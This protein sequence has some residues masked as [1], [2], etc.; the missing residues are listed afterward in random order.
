MINFLE[1]IFTAKAPVRE[2][3]VQR[4]SPFTAEQKSTSRNNYVRLLERAERDADAIIA[5][6]A[7][8]GECPPAALSDFKIKGFIGEGQ[9][10]RVFKVRLKVKG[11]I[12]ALKATKK[13]RVEED[14][15]VE[16][17]FREK[18]LQ[19]AMSFPFI[20]SLH[21]AFHDAKCVYLVTE[22]AM[23]GDLFSCFGG[24]KLHPRMAKTF[25]AQIIM[26]LE[27]MHACRLA[28]RDLKPGNVFIFEDGYVKLG[29]FG[30]T[31]KVTAKTFSTL[32]TAQYLA[33]EVIRKAGHTMAVDWWS[34][35]VML[36]EFLYGLNPFCFDPSRT[37]AVEIFA[38][39]SEKNVLI[40]DGRESDVAQLI[41][42]FLEKESQ[43]RLGTGV[44]DMDKIRR[45]P[46]FGDISF[47]EL[48]EKR[49]DFKVK[50][51]PVKIQ[52]SLHP[53]RLKNIF[54]EA[55][56]DAFEGF[57]TSSS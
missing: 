46:W 9:F 37:E 21:Y 17:L 35:G 1:N 20:V 24:K 13:K 8:A 49:I 23:Y 39:I 3:K 52:F 7:G 29:D 55:P 43:N 22:F 45:N 18:R 28:Y 12:L 25:T 36:F 2:K 42:G 54:P 14:D 26:A 33:P 27:Y 32:G 50:L 10:S 34:L 11:M 38:Q 6:D 5:Q 53:H 31:K 47:E 16:R 15:A 44:A 57:T 30:F 4:N 19:W 48:F 40:P 51:D 41:G 56:E